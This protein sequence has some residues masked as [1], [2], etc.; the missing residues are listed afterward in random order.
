MKE[1]VI[2]LLFPIQI[3]V[4][5][6]K[7]GKNKVSRYSFFFHEILLQSNWELRLTWFMYISWMRKFKEINYKSKYFHFLVSIIWVLFH[8]IFNSCVYVEMILNCVEITYCSELAN[9]VAELFFQFPRNISH[10]QNWLFV[11]VYLQICLQ[12]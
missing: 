11:C 1:C 2:L 4:L 9:K 5:N 10:E 6:Q 3:N 12:T 7:N 8:R